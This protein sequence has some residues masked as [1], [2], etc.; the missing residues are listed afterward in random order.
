MAIN[1]PGPY[2][3]RVEYLPTI[4]G[5]Q[6]IPHVAR[7]NVDLEGT[8][9][10]GST[11]ANMNFNDINGATGVDLATLVEDYLAEFNALIRTDCDIVSV[12]LWKYPTAQSFDA[13]F[14]STYVPTANVGTAA[15]TAVSSGQEIFVFRTQE[16]GIM[17]INVMEGVNAAGS[18]VAYAGLTANQKDLVDFILDG[19]G[20]TYS[21]PFL[22]RDTSYPFAFIK[23]YPGQ[24]EALWKKRNGR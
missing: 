7:L 6:N 19:D 21:A 18:P 8:P 24:N 17:K 20:A 10:Q 9:A 13:V 23:D 11:F 16:G 15:G 3:I 14:W 22:A 2:E 5:V 1:Y 12:D 4:G